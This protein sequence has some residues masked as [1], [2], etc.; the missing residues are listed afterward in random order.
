MNILLSLLY[1][2][3]DESCYSKDGKTLIKVNN[4]SPHLRISAKCEIIQLLCFYKLNSLISFSFEENPNLTTIGKESFSNCKNLTCINLSSCNKLKIISMYAFY[5][6]EKVS[7]IFLP[8]GLLEIQFLS[9]IH[10]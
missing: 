8:K 5:S 1:K 3:I 6:C 9:L 7:E 10:I 2:D 4:T